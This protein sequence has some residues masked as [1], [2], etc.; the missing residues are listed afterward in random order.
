MQFW[1]IK[2]FSFRSKSTTTIVKK[3]RSMWHIKLRTRIKSWL[4]RNITFRGM[5]T[6]LFC[7]VSTILETKVIIL[8]GQTDLSTFSVVWRRAGEGRF[9]EGEG[10]FFGGEGRFFQKTYSSLSPKSLHN[11]W[12]VRPLFSSC[13]P[14]VRSEIQLLPENVYN[15]PGCKNWEHEL[16]KERSFVLNFSFSVPQRGFDIGRVHSCVLRLSKYWPPTKAV[17]REDKR[18]RR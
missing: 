16:I 11:I 18:S 15:S 7:H 1:Q 5:F 3:L 4:L 17:N 13:P 12:L 10:R 8:D 6:V 14:F 2:F 9:F